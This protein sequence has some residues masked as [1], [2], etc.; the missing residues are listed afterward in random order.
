MPTTLTAAEMLDRE[1][2]EIRRRVLDIAASF[3]RIER[4][5]EASAVAADPRIAR[6]REAI[7][8]LTDNQGDR[9]RR[10]QMAFSDPYDAASCSS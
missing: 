2:L 6:L 1:F 5:P 7:G 3:D 10:I 9:A 8:L 4:C